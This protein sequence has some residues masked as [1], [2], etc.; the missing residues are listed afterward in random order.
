MRDVHKLH[1]VLAWDWRVCKD[2]DSAGRD[3]DGNPIDDKHNQGEEE[4]EEADQNKREGGA[5]SGSVATQR[6]LY[7]TA[8][9]QS[10]VE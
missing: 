8:A 6:R 2:G 4:E 10:K 3:A 5:N 1:P 7:R 9:G